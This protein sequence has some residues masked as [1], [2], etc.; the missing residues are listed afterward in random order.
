MLG[1]QHYLV[2]STDRERGTFSAYTAESFLNSKMKS[3]TLKQNQKWKSEG[4]QTVFKMKYSLDGSELCEQFQALD[5]AEEECRIG[6]KWNTSEGFVTKIKCDSEYFFDDRCIMSDDVNIKSYTTVNSSI[7]LEKGDHLLLFDLEKS[8]TKH[9]SVLVCRCIDQS[10][11]EVIPPLELSLT[12]TST[13]VKLEHESVDLTKYIVYRTNYSESLPPEDVLQR[14]NSAI[15]RAILMKDGINP[16]GF[17]SWAKTGRELSVSDSESEIKKNLQIADRRPLRYEKIMSPDDIKIGDHL[18]T[19]DKLDY[20]INDLSLPTTHFF[21]TERLKNT[22]NPIFK[23]ITLSL[24]TIKE[25]EKEFSPLAVRATWP[26]HRVI[27]PE[28]FSFDLAVKRARSLVGKKFSALA[29]FGSTMLR[30]IKTGSEEG[31]EINFLI[32]SSAPTSKSQIACFTQLNPG[33]Y[34]IKQKSQS[35]S[36]ITKALTF[37]NHY[38]VVSVESPHECTVIE[39]WRRKVEKKPI[40]YNSCSANLSYYRIN[41]DPGQ[42][43]PAEHSIEIAEKAFSNPSSFFSRYWKPNSEFARKGF[44]HFIKTGER[45]PNIEILQDD[46][47]FLQRE[48]VTS[49]LNLHI[50]DHIER[51]LSLAPEHAQHHMLVMEPINH[52]TCKVIHYRVEKSFSRVVQFKKGD[53]VNEEVDIFICGDVFRIVYPERTDPRDGMD[54]LTQ[55]CEEGK[56]RL[57]GEVGKV[58]VLSIINK[59]NSTPYTSCQ[60]FYS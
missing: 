53:V 57:H 11:V 10:T 17:A 20:F 58:S 40:V 39:S 3:V 29:I 16:D 43:F 1:K 55:I 45:L 33:D 49:A 50:G 47:F 13:K 51:P 23:V 18:F 36:A 56:R 7:S 31:L 5:R 15:G 8:A 25:V 48:L 27:Y 52:S 28:E 46:R 9:K 60:E 14:A 19:K 22:A 38:I 42:C 34:L 44:I 2:L 12:N 54:K 4:S 24:G 26:V 30:W 32:D 37:D 21:V 6:S 59:P 35:D 41:Y